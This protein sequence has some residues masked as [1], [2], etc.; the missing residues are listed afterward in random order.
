MNGVRCLFVY[1]LQSFTEEMECD[2]VDLVQLLLCS[3]PKFEGVM[4]TE[5]K[6]KS[7]R[8][9]RKSRIKECTSVCM[10]LVPFH[11]GY[12]FLYGCL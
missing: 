12:L 6:A 4:K 1:N 9:G 7:G 8:Y 10:E 2:A 11:V 3:N 5:L